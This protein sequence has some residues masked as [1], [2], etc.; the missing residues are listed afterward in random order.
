MSVTTPGSWE[1]FVIDARQAGEVQWLHTDHR[2]G[3]AMALGLWRI[4]PDE[5][6]ELRYTVSG[7]QTIYVL[8][9][10]AELEASPAGPIRLSPRQSVTLSE[11]FVGTWRTFSPF[12]A[13]L[14]IASAEV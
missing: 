4:G 7:I 10:E 13:Y 1:P 2:M 9:G 8:E 14:V 12:V 3:G 6:A 5:G 11:G